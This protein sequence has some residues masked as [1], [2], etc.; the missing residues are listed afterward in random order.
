MEQYGEGFAQAYD[1]HWSPYPTRAGE[2]LLRLH[3]AL[4]PQAERRVL[5]IGCG[6]GIVAALFQQ[7]GYEVTGLDVSE[8]MLKRAR[9]R[10]GDKAVLVHGDATDF[11]VAEP[12]PLAVSTYDIPNHLG[13]P[14]R[15]RSYVEC[16]FRAV[17]PGG[18]FAFDVAAP[19]ALLGINAI[20][21]RETDDSILLYRGALNEEAGYGFYRISGVVRAPDGRYDRFET[22]ITN[23]VVSLGMVSDTLKDVGW[24]DVYLAAPTDLLTPLAG[25]QIATGEKLHRVCFIARR[26]E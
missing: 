19:K 14:E 5:D 25:D 23:W 12:F 18:V 7:A 21:V 13:T 16:V 15:I 26:P 2:Q 6:T 10:L 17:R 24:Q 8:A 1:E 3:Q 22:T 4:D 11:S 20:Q 9:T